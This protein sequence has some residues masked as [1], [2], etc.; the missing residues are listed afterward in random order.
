MAV[1]F[2]SFLGTGDYK[3]CRYELGTR[4][5]SLTRFVQHAILELL[6]ETR[7]TEAY[8]FLTPEA[9]EFNWIA[10]PKRG[11]PGLSFALSDLRR[12]KPLEIHTVPIPSQQDDD[13]IWTSFHAVLSVL[14]PGDR[15][16]F[17]ITHSM[18]YQPMLALLVL[19]FARVLREVQ[20]GGVY[21]GY[22]EKLGPSKQIDDIPVEKRIAPV[23][24]VTALADLQEWI[25]RTYAFVAAGRAEPLR[26]WV[27]EAR[28]RAPSSWQWAEELTDSWSSVTAALYTNRA[29]TIPDTARRAAK[30]LAEAPKEMPPAMGPLR[31][32]FEHANRSIAPLGS[33]DPVESGLAA[34]LWCIDHG[35]IQQAYTQ[36]RELIITAVGLA[37]G[38]PVQGKE[39]RDRIEELVTVA[40]KFAANPRNR[41][42]LENMTYPRDRD[43]VF[44]LSRHTGLLN[45]FDE[46]RKLRNDLSHCGDTH[47]PAYFETWLREHMPVVKEHLLRFWNTRQ[48]RR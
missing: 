44:T 47:S 13:A 39:E 20:L 22:I 18:R 30:H 33:Q 16:V 6:E 25:T 29:L 43:L 34:I 4:R 31:A 48:S 14:Q 27:K 7:P 26:Q 21:Y 10:T 38:L 11:Y 1:K 15:V 3:E 28:T 12:T 35:L 41:K 45:D 42:P 23:V 2:L 8:I 37:F 19:H 9:E 46:V 36:T 32:L 17:D 5:S 24:D 40:Q